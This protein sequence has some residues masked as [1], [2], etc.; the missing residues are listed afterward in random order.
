MHYFF[1][2]RLS[3]FYH[4]YFLFLKLNFDIHNIFLDIAE[5][6]ENQENEAFKV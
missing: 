2:N 1:K 4:F 6:Q 5:N 3:V